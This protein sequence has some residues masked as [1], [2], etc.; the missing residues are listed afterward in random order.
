M[1]LYLFF[2]AALLLPL[3]GQLALLRLGR[4]RPRLRFARW[5]PLL[6]PGIFLLLA[7]RAQGENGFFSGLVVLFYLAAALASLAGCGLGWLGD[8]VWRGKR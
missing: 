7:A 1:E 3:G 4:S 2:A 5:L 6:V 8:R